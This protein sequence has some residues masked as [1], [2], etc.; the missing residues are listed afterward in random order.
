MFLR[1]K[2]QEG[3]TAA[4][5][6][7]LGIRQKLQEALENPT[8]WQKLLLIAVLGAT[9]LGY[10][11]T[12][13]RQSMEEIGY[14]LAWLALTSVGLGILYRVYHKRTELNVRRSALLMLL[15]VVQIMIINYLRCLPSIEIGKFSVTIGQLLLA[16]PYALAPGMTAVMLGKKLGVFAT[17]CTTLV[18]MALMPADF[19]M[20]N[21]VVLSLVAGL[22]SALL[23]DRVARREKI[24][25]AGFVT[26][27]AV[28]VA[29]V[30]LGCFRGS[31]LYTLHGGFHVGGFA[32]EAAVALGVNF[33]VS[34]VVGGL[35][36]LMERL[37]KIST[38]ITWLEWSDMNHP[39]LR[40]LQMK[41]P[42]TFHH[43]LCVQRLAEA[44]AGA[45]GADVTCAGVCGLYHDIGKLEKP[46]YFTENIGSQ[47][48][49]P[50]NDHT[51]E[52]SAREII[53]HVKDGVEIAR[54]YKLNSRIIDAIREHHGKLLTFYFYCK[55]M[56]H[57]VEEK[58]KFDEGLIDTCPEEVSRAKF[59]Y[60][61]PIPQ[62]RESGIVS[63]ADAVESATRSL[64][65]PTEEERRSIVD[66]IFRERI[67]DGHLRDCQLTLGDLDKIKESFLTTL[68]TMN[69]SRI[70]YPPPAI[71]DDEAESATSVH[72]SK[73][74]S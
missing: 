58:K 10:I 23:C 2:L 6:K 47:A 65:N 12:D 19:T 50:H 20:A 68:S 74:A 14:R 34:V 24:L 4:S 67:L 3:L 8:A 64:V 32:A 15:I 72:Q 22:I 17:L 28:F 13:P 38:H 35:M 26:G 41:A 37:F 18:G 5:Q 9:V 33:V 30:A 60:E 71:Q 73:S 53:R 51:A 59:T 49:S 1:Q 11:V 44:A 31:G 66:K 42:G 43:S 61:G 57:Y 54:K 16:L 56:D 21:Y 40:E 52:A 70:A 55:A 69:H 39:I 25:Y 48:F 29:A 36:P 27:A 45:V 63:M 62:T 46:N 7:L